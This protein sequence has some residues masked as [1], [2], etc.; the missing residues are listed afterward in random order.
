MVS[1]LYFIY[2]EG[3]D[4]AVGGTYEA[5]GSSFR[6]YLSPEDSRDGGLN[7][8]RRVERSAR[9]T[10]AQEAGTAHEAATA[11]H[12]SCVRRASRLWRESE[13]EREGMAL[14]RSL[15]AVDVRE[16]I[17]SYDPMVFS[18]PARGDAWIVGMTEDERWFFLRDPSS[19]KFGAARA[20]D[21]AEPERVRRAMRPVMARLAAE[22]EAE[23]RAFFES[24]PDLLITEVVAIGEYGLSGVRIK[25][26]NLRQGKTIKYVRFAVRPYNPV[27]DRIP[28]SQG[29]GTETVRG[30]GPLEPSDT[31][32]SVFEWD[33]L[34][35][36]ELVVCAQ[37]SAV[38]VEYMDGTERRWRG[39]SQVD[40]LFR[41]PDL[42][43]RC[44]PGIE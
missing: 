37:I 7:Q 40:R 15:R 21:F 27:G 20:A 8:S 35:L 14:T 36:S 23:R 31:H 13:A 39:V 28:T 32:T 17:E 2:A 10:Q 19:E 1:E 9:L 25:F 43:N 44:E 30:V 42:W 29:G 22:R 6:V 3:D 16:G 18:I 11:A 34:W 4:V 38:T 5:A 26:A 12:A 41:F 24:T 33:S